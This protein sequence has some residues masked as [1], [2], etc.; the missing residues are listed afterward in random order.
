MRP[1][2]SYNFSESI[3]TPYSKE[4]QRGCGALRFAPEL[5]SEYRAASQ[6]SFSYQSQTAALVGTAI[7]ILFIG[8]DLLR[9]NLI[10]RYSALPP[11]LFLLV[12]VRVLVLLAFVLCVVFLRR[13]ISHRYRRMITVGMFLLLTTGTAIAIVVYQISGLRHENSVLLLTVIA[14][15]LPVGLTFREGLA[16]AVICTGAVALVGLVMLTGDPRIQ[17]M[18]LPFVLALATVAGALSA[19]L[20]EYGQREQFLLRSELQWHATRD[21]LTGLFNR[22]MFDHHL[23]AVIRQAQ[24]ERIILAL[25]LID[26]DHFKLYNDT[27]GHQ[28]GDIALQN[29]GTQ[30]RDCVMRPLDMAARIGGEEIALILYDTALDYVNEIC[31]RLL[32]DIHRLDIH[33]RASPTADRMTLSVGCTLLKHDESAESLY[34]R[35]DRLL[36]QAKREGRNRTVIDSDIESC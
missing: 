34:R 8:I 3:E 31:S 32:R 36:Y 19:Y 2:S 27:Y 16:L 24:R 21:P 22:R 4:L 15:F 5:E 20:H 18:R 12:A 35:A 10:Q 11:I 25:I 28:A 26:V 23:E 13:D 9:L 14:I 6:R 7:W 17:F 1:I 29:V 30:L 33:H